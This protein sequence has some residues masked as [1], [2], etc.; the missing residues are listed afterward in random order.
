MMR[1]Y[2]PLALLAA[3]CT[4]PGC[5]LDPTGCDGPPA[6]HCYAGRIVASTCMDGLLVEVDAR[7]PIGATAL[8]PG[9]G[10]PDSLLGHNVVAVVNTSDL[11][12]QLTPAQCE[13]GQPLYFTYVNDPSR[14]SNG[15]CCFAGDGVRGNIPRLVLS[16][17]AVTPCA[18]APKAN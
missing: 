1:K 18:P 13:V 3:S 6:P 8:R 12:S 10:Q 4:L 15:W 14:Q 16:N 17:V 11:H 2:L 5:Q 9:M 7:Y